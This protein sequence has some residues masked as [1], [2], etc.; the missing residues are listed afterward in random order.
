MCGFGINGANSPLFNMHKSQIL[1]YFLLAFVIGI[2]VAS[3]VDISYEAIL[4]MTI[5]GIGS[6]AVFGYQRTYSRKGLLG[7]IFFLALVVGMARFVYVDLA[8]ETLVQFADRYVKEKPISIIMGGYIDSEPEIGTKTTHFNFRVKKLVLPDRELAIDEKTSITANGAL[9][10]EIGDTLSVE[11]AVSSPQNF[12]EEF[13]YVNYLKKDV[14]KTVVLFPTISKTSDVKIGFWEKRVL[15][16]KKTSFAARAYFEESINR[17]MVEPNASYING[18]L[19]GSRQNIPDDLKEAFNKTG[20]T[21]ILAISGYN[22]MIIANALLAALV[23]FVRRRAAFW[24][25]VA[26]I[27]TFTVMTGGSSSVVRASIMGLMLLFAQGYGRMYSARNSIVLAG[28]AMIFLN[29]FALAFDIGFQ[30]SFLAVLGLVYLYPFLQRKFE[31]VPSMLGVKDSFLTTVSAQ[32][33]VGIP[34]IVYFGRFSWAFLPAN[35]LILPFVPFAM[36]A[37]LIAGLGQMILPGLGQ[38]ISIPAWAITSYQIWV[39][40]FLS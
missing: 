15:D 14:I 27:F 24:F 10:Y 11:G 7:S 39:I 36:L 23:F 35:I 5:V 4:V 38:I 2:F 26:A 20:T 28:A 3:L 25:S 32:A 16:F 21:H 37:G 31:K 34:I 19:L 12:D 30:L 40:R 33:F 13:N 22:I 29:P 1:F 8:N 18:I 17:S 9:F 6:L